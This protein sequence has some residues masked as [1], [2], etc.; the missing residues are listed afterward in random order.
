MI[1]YHY[2]SA[3][4]LHGIAVHGLTVGDVP[5]D[6][7]RT[8]GRVGVWLTTA[9]TPEGHGLEGSAADKARFRLEVELPD[10][11]PPLVRWLDWARDN[12]TPRTIEVLGRDRRPD[13]WHVYF[14]TIPVEHIHSCFDMLA[15]RD[16]ADWTEL[17]PVPLRV[18]GV[19]AW[20]RHA[21]HRQLL[22]QTKRLLNKA[23]SA[24]RAPGEL[25][26]E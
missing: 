5:T 23:R 18:P 12:A 1:L 6:I 20:R 10:D 8:E 2:T 9:D 19:P 7:D 3:R 21:W 17:P 4:H 11:A 14:G 24:R 15:G 26:R 16:I 25:R 22:K 13:T